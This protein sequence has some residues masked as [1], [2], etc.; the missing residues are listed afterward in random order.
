MLKKIK[1]VSLLPVLFFTIF[2][3]NTSAQNKKKLDQNTDIQ[4]ITYTHT[5]GRGGRTSITATKDSLISTA[6][7][8]R[9]TQTPKFSKK[10]NSADW[11]KLVSAIN[12]NTLEKTKSGAVRGVYDGSDEIFEIKTSKKEYR[13]VNVLDSTTNYKQLG[14][15]KTL[16]QNMVSQAK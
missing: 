9:F 13:L 11:K 14:S 6:T 15:V 8:G 16:L 4:A 5:A 12:I 10:I 7:G 1:I 2:S 3:C